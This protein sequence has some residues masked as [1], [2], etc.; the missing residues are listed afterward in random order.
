[1]RYLGGWLCGGHH[2]P[3][4]VVDVVVVVVTLERHFMDI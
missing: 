4:A 2:M 3:N 1:M